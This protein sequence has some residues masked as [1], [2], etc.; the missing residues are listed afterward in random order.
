MKIKNLVGLFILFCVLI[1]N[2]NV[3]AQ[4]Q[5]SR[6]ASDVEKVVIKLQQK[7]LLSSDQT[8]KVR[9]I[10]DSYING[11]KSAEDLADAQK[12]I[13]TLLDE[14]QKEKYNII[15]EDWWKGVKKVSKAD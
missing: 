6:S 4:K 7:V 13:E 3:M 5:D 9:T 8:S 12:K 1:A 10:I 11:D 14:K 15:K 2:T